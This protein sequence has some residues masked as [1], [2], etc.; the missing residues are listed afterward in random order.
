LNEYLD[1]KMENSYVT[2]CYLV[3]KSAR[4]RW[5]GVGMPTNDEIDYLL[6]GIGRLYSKE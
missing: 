1:L 3:D 2:Y 5:K 6:K 4:I